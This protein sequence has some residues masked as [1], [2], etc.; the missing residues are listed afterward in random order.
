MINRITTTDTLTPDFQALCCTVA[1]NAPRRDLAS[2]RARRLL[3]TQVAQRPNL[4]VQVGTRGRSERLLVFRIPF[5]DAS[6]LTGG[7]CLAFPFVFVRTPSS[8]G[9]FPIPFSGSLA[10]FLEAYR[11]RPFSA[12][13]L[14]V[15]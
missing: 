12:T 13:I 11:T 14:R 3:S 7:Y 6:I 4:G 15:A 1:V 10:F 9:S 8:D 5:R 2:A